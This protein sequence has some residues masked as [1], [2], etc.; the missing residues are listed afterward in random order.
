MKWRDEI[1]NDPVTFR[2]WLRDT[3]DTELM[4]IARRWN[5]SKRNDTQ[6]LDTCK[7]IATEFM[8]RIPDRDDPYTFCKTLYTHNTI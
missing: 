5:K 1:T 7:A 3:N 6:A 4:A 2:L 8:N